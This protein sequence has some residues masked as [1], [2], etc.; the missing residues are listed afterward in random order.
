MA[1]IQDIRN[2]L[3]G[4]VVKFIVVLIVIAFVGSIGWSA[5]FSSSDVNEVASVDDIKI[6]VTDL[7]FEMRAQDYYFQERKKNDLKRFNSFMESE[8]PSTLLPDT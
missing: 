8:D 6:D 4:T 5:F 7:N 1:G 3:D 2:N